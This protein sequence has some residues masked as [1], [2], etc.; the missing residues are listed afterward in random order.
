MK[1]QSIGKSRSYDNSD[2][3]IKQQPG[4]SC[5]LTQEHFCSNLN[6]GDRGKWSVRQVF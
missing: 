5:Y 4:E 3:I 1:N 2:E 6:V